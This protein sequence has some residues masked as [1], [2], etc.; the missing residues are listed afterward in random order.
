LLLASPLTEEDSSF[1]AFWI[2]TIYDH[3]SVHHHERLSIIN[4]TTDDT[5][6]NAEAAYR[7]T[8]TFSDFTIWEKLTFQGAPDEATPLKTTAT[9]VKKSTCKLKLA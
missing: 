4:P 5:V 9:I 2:V 6:V 3:I 7:T 1:K 8:F